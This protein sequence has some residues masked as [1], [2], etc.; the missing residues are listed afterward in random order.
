MKVNISNEPDKEVIR[1]VKMLLDV[2]PKI[3]E[4]WQK[5]IKVADAWSSGSP[6]LNIMKVIY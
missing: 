2:C 3:I 6:L 1:K 5:Y 4:K